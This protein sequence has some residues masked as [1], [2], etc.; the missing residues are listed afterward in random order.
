MS[1]EKAE[2][3]IREA[4]ENLRKAKEELERLKKYSIRMPEVGQR[5][6]CH[7]SD[8]IDKWEYKENHKWNF[9]S[10]EKTADSEFKWHNAVRELRHIA[11]ELNGGTPAGVDEWCI[12]Q[13]GPVLEYYYNTLGPQIATF[14]T[15]E[16]AKKAKEMLSQESADIL[17]IEK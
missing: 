17:G 9:Y 2:Q 10:D 7:F 15:E 3:Q 13:N 4:E 1:I 6:Y 16:L 5:V 14:K 12:A 11:R 8:R